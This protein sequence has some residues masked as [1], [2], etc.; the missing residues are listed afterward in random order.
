MTTWK[1]KTFAV[2]MAVLIVMSVGPAPA[3]AATGL[4][5]R[6]SGGPVTE[7]NLIKTADADGRNVTFLADFL[8]DSDNYGRVVLAE[9]RTIESGT[10]GGDWSA[11]GGTSFSY[12]E[13]AETLYM[14]VRQRVA[15]GNDDRG[16]EYEMW[17]N[18]EAGPN[19]D[20]T[21]A[22][23]WSLL[24]EED[25]TDDVQS[26]EETALRQYPDENGDTK[27]FLYFSA[28]EGTDSGNQE[29]H[30][31]IVSADTVTG[32]Q[33]KLD[34]PS[35][36][37]QAI[38]DSQ[39]ST[40]KGSRTMRFGDTYYMLAGTADGTGG[41][42]LVR[43]TDANFSSTTVVGDMQDP[44]E[45]N[46][47]DAID[48]GGGPGQVLY[49]ADSERFLYWKPRSDTNENDM[50]W[51]F[52]SDPEFENLADNPTFEGC[53]NIQENRTSE[54]SDARYITYYSLSPTR[55]I[56]S[57]EWDPDDDDVHDSY[58]WDYRGESY[59][60]N[61]HTTD[62][63]LG[64]ASLTN[65][66][67]TGTGDS[68]FVEDQNL[69]GV[70][71]TIDSFEDQDLSEYSGDTGS[72]SIQSSDAID[73]TYALEATAG[74]SVE[75]IS[76]SGL[77]HYPEA[78]DE[79][80]FRVK[81]DRA[82]D[83][84]TRFY[85]GVQ[86]TNNYYRLGVEADNQADL[87]VV[88]GGS[89]TGLDSSSTGDLVADEWMR[90]VVDWQSDGSITVTF[91]D[92]S[93]VEL[94]TLSATDST[95]SS[96]GIGFLQFN[97]ANSETARW[98]GVTF[99]S[100]PAGGDTAEY[101]GDGH[102]FGRVEG[103]FANVTEAQD[104]EWQLTAEEWDGS[105]WNQIATQ[106]GLRS[107]ENRTLFFDATS[108]DKTRVKVNLT[109]SGPNPS[110]RMD[111]EGILWQPSAPA[112]SN[113]SPQDGISDEDGNITLSADV[114]DIDLGTPQGDSVTV[115]FYLDGS[116]NGTYTITSNE[117]VTHDITGMSPEE[118]EWFVEAEDSHGA[119]A[120]TDSRTI[121]T[122]P[123]MT[124]KDV[125][126]PETVLDNDTIEAEFDDGDEVEVLT[127][128][129]GRIQLSELPDGRPL[130]V[131]V[132]PE[133]NLSHF[134]TRQVVLGEVKH[135]TSVYLLN[136]S[137]NTGVSIRFVVEDHTGRF[138]D[139]STRIVVRRALNV[140]GN[141]TYT[142]VASGLQGVNGFTT[143]LAQD[144]TYQIEVENTDTGETKEFGS[145]TVSASE[146]VTLEIHDD[147]VVKTVPDQPFLS[148]NPDNQV[149]YNGSN[150]YN[151]TVD[152]GGYD[153]S[154]YTVE[155][156]KLNG[157]ET[158][159]KSFSGTNSDGETFDT[160]IDES[161]S[162]ARIQVR[163][164][165]TSTDGISGTD[166]HTYVIRFKP[167]N[168]YGLLPVLGNVVTSL[169][170]STQDQFTSFMAFVITILAIGYAA[171]TMSSDAA[172]LVGL[173]SIGFFVVISWIPAAWL[174]IAGVAWLAG[175]G[176][177]NRL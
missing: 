150:P 68:A 111:D 51:C 5:P 29:W 149:V 58:I 16:T 140:S 176:V 2:V 112:I 106:D 119:T 114:D 77:E 97:G 173:A 85:F 80:S 59:E 152:A 47:P 13:N 45:N 40:N 8:N 92:E 172:G 67:V 7:N 101:V 14:I 122:G 25:M 81:H 75:I 102:D 35:T 139:D 87:Q 32:L 128:D 22:G 60:T 155:F 135:N 103:V 151:A 177:R 145:Y 9:D 64:S 113:R 95:Y 109:V 42:K 159:L 116:V 73:G 175:W 66:T 91:Y 74:S 132:N 121:F 147:G 54:S 131:R 108:T 143:I 165:W 96:G 88:S 162:G 53:E 43:G 142:N 171:S 125:D 71:P 6:Q 134:L 168:E 70:D 144:I 11:A 41:L 38:P 44:I 69:N 10:A 107:E 33:S 146:T 169:P 12:D 30:I 46:E 100:A 39:I 63:D 57:M 127:T 99:E 31:Q 15:D 61:I 104:V 160:V 62:G 118:H 153:L 133:D 78:G 83:G 166:N 36:W 34:D 123:V 141:T 129:N 115:R 136:G 158:V 49:D 19:D 76:T 24:W 161:E 124:F 28:D 84:A 120:T 105:S 148:M 89:A 55:N 23:N 50:Y 126:N 4:T 94:T 164:S 37:T 18:T 157:T 72:F 156:V 26:I 48:S 170:S 56:W 117:T 82:S 52:T 20:I 90:V 138:P 3:A 110:F 65:L 86:D 154:S 17:V 137:S 93:G 27:W 163:L 130:T 1:L 98:D 79:F 167:N 174:M 21:D